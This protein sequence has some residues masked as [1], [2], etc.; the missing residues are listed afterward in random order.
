MQ[1]G[2][3][4]L[5]SPHDKKLGI[6]SRISDLFMAAQMIDYLSLLATWAILDPFSGSKS[7]SDTPK[8]WSWNPFNFLVFNFSSDHYDPI[9]LLLNLGFI[10]YL[11]IYCLTSYFWCVISRFRS[12]GGRMITSLNYISTQSKSD[13][14]EH[15]AP[16]SYVLVTWGIS[17]L[18]ASCPPLS[19]IFVI[20]VI[21][22]SANHIL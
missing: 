22:S 12:R 19:D 9:F 4:S 1:F 16:I 3:D 5:H 20:F 2:C 11:A 17:S 15:L 18:G 7:T 14:S 21:C 13:C 8:C 10:Q 6:S